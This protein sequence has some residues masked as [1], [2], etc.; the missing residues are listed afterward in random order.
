M[1][2]RQI[3]LTV[4]LAAALAPAMAEETVDAGQEVRRE[5][6]VE[7]VER[8]PHAVHA[9]AAE[10]FRV[11]AH[12]YA[13]AT[14]GGHIAG[15]FRGPRGPVKNAPY[16]AEAVSERVQVLPDGNQIVKKH[17]TM[18]YRDSQG[19]TRQEIRGE[20]GDMRTILIQDGPVTFVLNPEKKTGTRISPEINERARALASEARERARVHVER[21][22]KERSKDGEGEAT[23]VRRFEHGMPEGAK[24][25]EE[26]SVRV[27]KEMEGKAEQL[28]RLAPAIA[29][30]SADSKFARNATVK[31]LGT[32]NFEGV[33]AE[34]KMSSY[35]IPA[36]EVGNV[37]P[38]VVTDET[39]YSPDLQ[40][41]V[42]S[43]HSDP[44]YGD[45]IYRLENIRRAEPSAELFA[46][47]SDFDIKDPAERLKKKLEEKAAKKKEQQ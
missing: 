2:T 18:S 38:I 35:E 8:A 29:R 43:K 45:R 17:S 41:T 12:E 22:R 15:A 34:G 1:M 24:R 30:A 31:D 37:R 9:E 36:G 20:D 33:K 7:R 40:V 47:P 10:R 21:I 4:L 11:H 28:R 23:V 13:F 3:L 42:Y 32:R 39:W 5:V 25:A 14:H 44:R 6:R 27:V 26:V 19:R 16:S 46:A